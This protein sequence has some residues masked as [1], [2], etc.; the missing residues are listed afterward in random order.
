MKK[1]WMLKDKNNSIYDVYA[2][3]LDEAIQILVD[4]IGGNK[5]D[6]VERF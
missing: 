3:T 4:N 5:T 1:L 6:Y 2:K